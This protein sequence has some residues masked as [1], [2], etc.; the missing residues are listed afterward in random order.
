MT[1]YTL[2]PPG[3]FTV[4]YM[5][6]EN[7]Y[8]T[9]DNINTFCEYYRYIPRSRRKY[10]EVVRTNIRKM[11]LDIDKYFD[12]ED[13]YR[14]GAELSNIIYEKYKIP[15][16]LIY[17]TSSLYKYH[18]VVSNISFTTSMCKYLKFLLDPYNNICDG[19]VYKSVQMIRMEG[20]AKINM[21]KY[22]IGC[23]RISDNICFIS[24]PADN[25][26][27][28]EM[29]SPQMSYY[30]DSSSIPRHFKIRKKSGNLILLDRLYP[31]FC[32]ECNR[33]HDRENAY[34]YFY[35]GSWRFG[36]FRKGF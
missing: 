9:F 2:P 21:H 4:F 1:S 13:I 28:E 33:V 20:S 34:M 15:P 10:Y 26:V 32:T 7:Y 24:T 22:V 17:Y 36:C 29:I 23:D 14:I 5:G 19:S 8:Q 35:D 30:S 18:I 12:I 6:F 11:I 27:Y 31:A 3:K 25:I 16:N